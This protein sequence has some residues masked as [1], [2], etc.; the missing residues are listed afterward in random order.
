[1]DYK[2]EILQMMEHVVLEWSIV[3]DDGDME[4]HILPTEIKRYYTLNK[5]FISDDVTVSQSDNTSTFNAYNMI[6]H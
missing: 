5:Y 1:M 3:I 2:D 6:T 4:K